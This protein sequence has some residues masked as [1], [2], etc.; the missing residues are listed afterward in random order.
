VLFETEKDG[1]YTGHSPEYAEISAPCG[2][3]IR[4][5]IY[6]VKVTQALG[7]KAVGEVISDKLSAVNYI[8]E[9]IS[10]KAFICSQFYCK[11]FHL[12]IEKTDKM[13]YNNLYNKLLWKT[14]SKNNI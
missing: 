5:L 8:S 7:D 11:L 13:C 12:P 9:Q 2:F 14:L 10:V 6:T 4:N 1:V 3:D